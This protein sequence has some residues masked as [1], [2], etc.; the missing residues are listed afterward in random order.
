MIN[1]KYPQKN[2][3]QI[4]GTQAWRAFLYKSPSEWDITLPSEDF[5]WDGYVEISSG[6]KVSGEAFFVQVK[7]KEEFDYEDCKDYVSITLKVSTLN[8]LLSKSTLSMLC[9]CDTGNQQEPVYW[10]WLNEAVKKIEEDNPEWKKQDTVTI[11]VPISQQYTR[12]IK[13][14]IEEDIF[15]FNNVKKIENEIF[16]VLVNPLG[17]SGVELENVSPNEV[18]NIIKPNLEAAGLI[19]DIPDKIETFSP[20]E[21]ELLKKIKDISTLLNNY[22]HTKSKALLEEIS[23]EIKNVSDSIK[24]R[25]YNNYG[26]LYR[27]LGDDIKALEFH[28]KAYSLS[29]SNPKYITN[30]LYTEYALMI[31]ENKIGPKKE[32][33]FENKLDNVIKENSNYHPSV[34]LKTYWI[35]RKYG[36]EKAFDFI[37]K[38]DTWEKEPLESHICIAEIYIKTGQ[39]KK[40]ID[41]LDEVKSLNLPLDFIFWDFYGFACFALSTNIT[42]FQREYYIF[43]AGPANPDYEL[44]KKSEECYENSYRSLIS[45][46]LPKFSEEIILNYSSVL[47]LLNKPERCIHICNSYL[48][49]HPDSLNIQGS[50]ALGYISQRK[51]E[52]AIVFSKNVFSKNP[53]PIT[54]KNHC[55]CLFEAEEYERLIETV[56]NQSQKG[57]K[58]KEQESLSRALCAIAYNEIGEPKETENEIKILKSDKTF[59]AY[60]V[61]A[62]AAIAKKNNLTRAEIIQIY[63]KGLEVDPHNTDLLTNFATFLKPTETGEA[64]EIIKCYKTVITKRELFPD[65]YSAFGIAYLTLNKSDEGKRILLRAH[66]QWPHMIR[67]YYDLANACVADGDEETAYQILQKCIKEGSSDYKII[68]NMAIL[69]YDT[70]RSDETIKLLSKALT[71]THDLQERGEIHCQLYELKRNKGFMPK[72]ILKH[73]HEFSKTIQNDPIKEARYLA[74]MMF[75]LQMSTKEI[76]E[77]TKE[78][79]NE[80]GKRLKIFSEQYPNSPILKTIKLNLDVPEQERG[81][82]ILSSLMAVMLPQMLRSKQIAIAARN[83]FWPLQLRSQYIH[84][85]HSIFEYWSICINSKEKENTIYIW[86]VFNSLEAEDNYARNA[87]SICIDISG[88]LTLAELDLLDTLH[89]FEKIYITRSTKITIDKELFNLNKKPHELAIKVESWR[90]SNKA[91]IRIKNYQKLGK[92]DEELDGDDFAKTGESNIFIRKPN[93]LYKILG[94]GMGE[95]VL[96]AKTLGLPLYSDD[97]TLRLWAS[98]GYNVET[99]CTINLL[100]SLCEKNIANLDKVTDI[101]A[102]MIDKN[103]AIIPFHPFHLN[104]NLKKQIKEYHQKHGRLPTADELKSNNTFGI[105]VRQFGDPA[106]TDNFLLDFIPNWWISIINERDIPIEI[107]PECMGYPSFSF[108]IRTVG[109]AIKGISKKEQSIRYAALWAH[110]LLKSF[111]S[112][113]D[114]ISSTWSAIKTVCEKYNS[115]DESTYNKILYELIP[116]FLIDALTKSNIHKDKKIEMIVALTM[117]LPEPE[118]NKIDDY[119]Q[120]HKPNFML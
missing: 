61:V 112:N 25:Y 101:F 13:N 89:V 8:L 109:G 105:L 56:V 77:E 34:R 52:K 86:N 29:P 2:K 15:K 17:L 46:G 45:F 28:K 97:S 83:G 57:F 59:F 111:L 24:A 63:K 113:H 30:T 103:F 19:D 72:E 95:S 78:W 92:E 1:N 96:L 4:T 6:G 102:K 65:E 41:I 119:I 62:E 104:N 66:E 31:K 115:N 74:M 106:L 60:G 99:F 53:N 12:D 55:I 81:K 75:P 110:F 33:Q 85:I 94:D 11:R 51:P 39:Y 84:N 114:Y 26:V 35:A 36:Q 100:N 98:Q 10:V 70:G 79:F 37:K 82:E 68:K 9:A 73:V 90:L 71:K 87:R 76:E 120:K 3:S 43:G 47:H 20:K 18:F 67:F 27:H 80:A 69:A 117:S 22:N 44:L 21:Q 5:G 23:S 107:L 42:S 118:K 54:Y 49:R 58:D 116:N 14:N 7:G 40:A 16:N 48:E 32:K 93:P 108:S 88:L 50:I 38:T 64:E 91:K